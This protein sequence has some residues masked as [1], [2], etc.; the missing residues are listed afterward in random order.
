MDDLE[1]ILRR[2]LHAP[3]IAAVEAERFRRD[4]SQSALEGLRRTT[5]FIPVD[6][7]AE[8][9]G[10]IRQGDPSH[11]GIDVAEREIDFLKIETILVD[12]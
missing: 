10:R 1:T 12:A 7:V 2:V 8:G 4:R 9:G 11:T 6:W 5:V 3:G